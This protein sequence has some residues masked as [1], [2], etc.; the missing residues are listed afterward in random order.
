MLAGGEWDVALLQECPPRFAEPLAARLRRRG[1]PG[2]DLAQLARRR[3][4]RLA[5]AAQPRP[6]RLR[7]GR[8]EPDPGAGAGALGGIVE[9]REM[10]IHEGRPERRAMAFTRTASGV[11]VANLHATNDIPD[12]AAEDVLRRGG[13]G[14]RVG[15]RRAAALRRRP[16][17]PARARTRRLRR[18]ARRFGLAGPTA[19]DAI[20]HLLVRGLERRATDPLA[21]RAAGG[22][23]R[24]AGAAPLRPRAGR[25]QVRT[26]GAAVAE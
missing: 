9:R 17:P 11:C 14:D 6:D 4:A 23:A 25:G 19:P 2:A 1:A 7:R 3:C 22:R 21:G 13:G 20:D 5:A 15:G 24:R 18:A 10:A 26:A 16:Q 8:L 12:L